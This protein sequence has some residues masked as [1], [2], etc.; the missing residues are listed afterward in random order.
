[1]TSD[2]LDGIVRSHRADPVAVR[3]EAAQL[4][5]L[6][7]TLCRRH[8]LNH[9]CTNADDGRPPSRDA[10]ELC[11]HRNHRRDVLHAEFLCSIVG[12]S[13]AL[14]IKRDYQQPAAYHSVTRDELRGLA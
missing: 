12:G 6:V 5:R 10:A 7:S 11:F 1:M 3:E 9:P 4:D 13:G 14:S 2:I 8:A